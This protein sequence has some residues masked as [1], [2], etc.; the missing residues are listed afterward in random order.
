MPPGG[1]AKRGPS[2]DV[3]ARRGGAR[4]G[5]VHQPLIRTL[6]SP[7]VRGVGGGL[8]PQRLVWIAKLTP[9]EQYHHYK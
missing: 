6:P 1:G 8:P 9:Y 4:E 7:R 2:E 3:H 5:A